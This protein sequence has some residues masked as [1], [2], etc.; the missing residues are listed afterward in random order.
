[1]ENV[2]HGMPSWPLDIKH[3]LMT[4][5]V[6]SHYLPGTTHNSVNIVPG[7]PEYPLDSTH[8]RLTSGVFYSIDLGQHIQSD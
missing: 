4:S 8:G 3:G 6:A 5:S 7:M 1:M 2:G